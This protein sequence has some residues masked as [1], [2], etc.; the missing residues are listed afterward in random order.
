MCGFIVYSQ[1]RILAAVA[2]RSGPSLF[3]HQCM[4]CGHSVV[5]R[6]LLHD[7]R[8]YQF[9]PSSSWAN[10]SFQNSCL[11]EVF[12]QP[13]YPIY[14]RGSFTTPGYMASA[15][16]LQ[17]ICCIE[18]LDDGATEAQLESPGSGLVY[19]CIS[20]DGLPSS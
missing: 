8:L 4:A 17:M 1:L 12:R 2:A 5:R 11:H 13:H 20:S 19:H 6:L 16:G 14:A 10:L 15:Y 7:G 9:F 3:S 18:T